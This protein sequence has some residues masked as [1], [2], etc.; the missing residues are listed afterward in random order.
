[1]YKEIKYYHGL[2]DHSLIHLIDLKDKGEDIPLIHFKIDVSLD[3]LL[4]NIDLL[5][6]QLYS[7]IRLFVVISDTQNF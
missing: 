7:L 4:V 2:V 1:M 5:I 6:L 3:I